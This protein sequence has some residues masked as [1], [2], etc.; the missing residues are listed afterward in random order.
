MKKGKKFVILSLAA[1]AALSI[2]VGAAVAVRISSERNCGRTKPPIMRV[3]NEQEPAESDTNGMVFGDGERDFCLGYL[4]GFR[5]EEV[6]GDESAAEAERITR[7]NALIQEYREYVEAL[8]GQSMTTE[9]YEIHYQH[10]MDIFCDELLPLEPEPT[11][12]KQIEIKIAQLLSGLKDD[13]CFSEINGEAYIK[14]RRVDVSALKKS[15]E[16]LTLLQEK[17]DAKQLTLEQL[18]QEFAI[19]LEVVKKASPEIYEAWILNE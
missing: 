10:L 4:E 3:D 7:K 16:D 17:I 18:Q 14:S 1:L 8:Y 9:E 2:P 15:I 13:L 19:C 6:T 5:D 12:E 11:P